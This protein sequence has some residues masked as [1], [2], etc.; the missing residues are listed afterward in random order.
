ME[1]LEE[2]LKDVDGKEDII[3]NIKKGIGENFVAKDDFNNKNNEVKDLKEQISERDKQLE[4][5]KK[6]DPKKLQEE[7]DTLKE[8]NAT[9]QAEYDA[10]IHNL[11][12]ESALDKALISSGAKNTKAV[13]ALLDIDVENA[14]FDEAGN[15]ENI[16]TMLDGIKTSDPY[17]FE[18]KEPTKKGFTGV[19]P[20][21]GNP[22]PG[23]KPDSEKSYEDFVKELESK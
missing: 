18:S 17:L 20:D 6:V 7:I 15:L 5:L 11:K 2:I 8:A 13:K 4:D 23:V 1:W 3:K 16:S 19:E 22:N 14:K 12:V 21:G 9:K 10:K